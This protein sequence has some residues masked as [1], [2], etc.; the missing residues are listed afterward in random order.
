MLKAIF[1]FELK[2]RLTSKA[3]WIAFSVLVLFALRD[4]MSA[5]W[6]QL[7]GTGQVYRNSAFSGYYIMMFTCFWAAMMGAG[8]A[9]SPLLKDLQTQAAPILYSKPISDKEYFLGKYLAAL[10]GMT[11]VMLGTPVGFVLVEY[12]GPVFLS[13]DQLQLSGTPWGPLF[14]AYVIW[15]LTAVVIFTS[16]H[17]ALASMTG[18]LLGSYL[19]VVVL[20]LLWML[21][22]TFLR[23]SSTTDWVQIIDPIGLSTVEGQ[24]LYWTVMER[25]TGYM[26][27]WGSALLYN[28]LLYV[29]LALAFLAIALWRFDLRKLLQKNRKAPGKKSLHQ[30]ITQTTDLLDFHK[31]LT[32]VVPHFSW[33]SRAK[34]V[35]SQGTHEWGLVIKDRYFLLILFFLALFG[36]TVTTGVG[37]M[38]QPQN[39]KL[40]PESLEQLGQVIDVFFLNGLIISVFYIGEIMHRDATAKTSQIIHAT[41]VSSAAL[42]MSKIV[43]VILLLLMLAVI[44]PAVV[45]ITQLFKGVW[46]LEWPILV[47]AYLFKTTQFMLAFGATTVLMHVLA[48]RKL[49]GNILALFVIISVLIFFEFGTLEHP[50]LWYGLPAPGVGFSIFNGYM[51]Q[52]EMLSMV[53]MYFMGLGAVFVILAYALWQRGTEYHVWSTLKN[54]ISIGSGLVSAVALGLL[55]AGIY[56]GYQNI[57]VLNDYQTRDE[58]IAE[59]VAYESAYRHLAEQRQPELRHVDAQFSVSVDKREVEVMAK[60]DLV[61]HQDTS[62]DTLWLQWPENM[63]DIQLNARDHHRLTIS[64]RDVELRQVFYRI[65]PPLQSGEALQALASGLVKYQG[66]DEEGRVGGIYPQGSHLTAE[67]LLPKIGYQSGREESLK[68]NRLKY[69]LPERTLLPSLETAD[70]V[71]AYYLEPQ[72]SHT[73][74]SVA[75]DNDAS[76]TVV[77]PGDDA[78]DKM[79]GKKAIN[80]RPMP[81]DWQLVLGNYDVMSTQWKNGHQAVTIEVYAHPKHTVN[82][83]VF[84]ETAQRALT[85]FTERYGAYEYDTLKIVELP[86][87][88]EPYTVG[89]MIA[90]P[91]ADGWLQDYQTGPGVD[92]IGYLISRELAKHWWQQK[93][94]PADLEGALVLTEGLPEYEAL[95]FLYRHQFQPDPDEVHWEQIERFLTR[96][97]DQYRKDVALENDYIDLLHTQDQDFMAQKAAFG[98]FDLSQ[99]LED[100]LQPVLNDFMRSGIAQTQG[101]PNLKQLYQRL[102]QSAQTLE[103]K[104]AIED[105]F[106]RRTQHNVR[107]DVAKLVSTDAIG[108]D[109]KISLYSERQVQD[110]AGQMNEDISPREVALMAVLEG[111]ELVDLPPR[112]IQPGLNDFTIRVPL[113]AVEVALNLKRAELDENISNNRKKL[114]P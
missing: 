105:L 4:V 18:K 27:F 51:A 71:T 24:V 79:H 101:L 48:G 1:L 19:V 53:V 84:T 68:G 6:D 108:K 92:W 30:K 85:D 13:S 111:G 11:I 112:T 8:F 109:V 5:Y 47:Q 60:M 25:N 36:F 77:M 98:L 59:R 76:Q 16:I 64:K 113:D 58:R 17:F 100:G 41:P 22:E 89:N 34:L 29:G 3:T 63:Q 44:P 31:T 39:G 95:A 15:G 40:L 88:A 83:G 86:A 46:P 80:T 50:M 2:A 37:D 45:A 65:E 54:R 62:L 14:H 82:A 55:G 73:T 103:Q 43:G 70:K 42:F 56:N 78:N 99:K 26:D 93:L 57:N 75:V 49:I 107:L 91:E 21:S 61:N 12:I 9:T 33:W 67:D 66:Y 32:P 90:L 10:V 35:L 87:G 106:A 23:N 114:S 74:W 7:I 81:F 97:Q 72:A 104:Q 110:A 20:M 94:N 102:I 52:W 69:S 28:R 38:H 96:F